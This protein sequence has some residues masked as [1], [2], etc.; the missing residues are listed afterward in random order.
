MP[1]IIA[2]VND[3]NTSVRQEAAIALGFRK[4]GDASF[5]A[6]KDVFLKERDVQVRLA[7]LNNLW[8][9]KDAFPEVRRIVQ[10]AAKRDGSKEV[11]KSAGEINATQS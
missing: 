1:L 11:R 2:L 7:V 10:T 8:K 6:Q 9:V 3:R 4:V 5:K